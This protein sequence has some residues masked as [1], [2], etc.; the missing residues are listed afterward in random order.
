MNAADILHDLD[1]LRRPG[2]R[3][4]VAPA[5]GICIHMSEVPDHAFSSGEAGVGFAISPEDGVGN[6]LQVVAP[7]AG[8]VVFVADN[9]HAIGIRNPHG[10]ECI[11]HIGLG[12]QQLSSISFVTSVTRGE[13]VQAG[14]HICRVAVSYLRHMEKAPV[15]VVAITNGLTSEPDIR[16]FHSRVRHGELL[17]AGI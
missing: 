5:D 9:G 13:S 10:I 1:D 16:R 14:D 7:I 12:T 15:V 4:L 2:P 11:V 8:T 6:D 3:D 17:M